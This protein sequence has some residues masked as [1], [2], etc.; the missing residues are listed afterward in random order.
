[1]GLITELLAKRSPVVHIVSP[2][3]TVLDAVAVMAARRVGAVP[4]VER[5]HLVGIFS[6]RDV[7]WRVVARGRSVEKTRIVEVMTP[8]PVT[9]EP[10]D[11]R[12]LAMLKMEEAGC[13]HLPVVQ[14]GAVVDMLSIRDLLFGELEERAEAVDSLRRYIG[15]SY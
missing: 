7:I 8:D 9:A 5:G 11:E 6:E 10:G 1:M 14:Y 4:V 12:A 2:D 3:Q 13:R 15:G